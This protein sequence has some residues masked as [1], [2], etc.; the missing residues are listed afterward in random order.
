MK[1]LNITIPEDIDKELSMYPNKSH[2]ISEAVKEKLKKE[3]QKK[4][5]AK[6]TEAYKLSKVEDMKINKD[7]SDVTLEEWE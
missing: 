2:F 7:W 1:R 4:I 3:K 6:L 5:D